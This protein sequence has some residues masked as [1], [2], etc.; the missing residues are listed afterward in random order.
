[1]RNPCSLFKTFFT[2]YHSTRRTR[3]LFHLTIC[4]IFHIRCSFT[5]HFALVR[6]TPL[7]STKPYAAITLFSR[8][9]F[10]ISKRIHN[11]VIGIDFYLF[12][13]Y[14]DR[15]SPFP[16]RCSRR[17]FSYAQI[18]KTHL[19]KIFLYTKSKAAKIKIVYLLIS[20]LL[21]E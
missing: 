20:S 15:Y 5:K 1:M 9:A 13:F 16:K 19:R 2:G 18:H 6:T 10:M 3:T 14:K 17:R 12:D 21:L 11:S 7:H 8:S 4:M